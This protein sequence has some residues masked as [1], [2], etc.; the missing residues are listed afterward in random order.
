MSYLPISHHT[1]TDFLNVFRQDLIT[2]T[3]EVLILS[4]FLSANR[5][6]HYYPILRSLKQ[7]EVNIKV[8]SKPKAEQPR[9]LKHHF[10]QVEKQLLN[11]GI[12]LQVRQ[13]MHEKVGILDRKILWHGS[14]NILS[15][16]DTKESMLRFES[17]EL[18]QLI[19]LELGINIPQ[20]TQKTEN[21]KTYLPNCPRCGQKMDWFSDSQLWICQDS[22]NCLGTLSPNDLN[23]KA[24][25]SVPET[26]FASLDLDCPICHAS[27]KVEPGILFRVYC[28][29]PDC[30]FILKPPLAKSLL[31]MLR[32][33]KNDARI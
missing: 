20:E 18:S 17:S 31:K 5:A 33:S 28:S 2:A 4:P 29:S 19:L 32:R 6:I 26:G 27:L 1:D 15:H 3:R 7:R 12:S 14:L 8:Y 21:L 24:E 30:D 13:G 22:P 10:D 16:N 11:L 25:E 23:Y 9:G